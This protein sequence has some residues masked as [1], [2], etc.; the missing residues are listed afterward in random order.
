MFLYV[1]QNCYYQKLED[2]NY[3]HKAPM[4][5]V[6]NP[7]LRFLQFYSDKPYVIATMTEFKHGKPGFV[8]YKIKRVG[9]NKIPKPNVCLYMWSLTFCCVFM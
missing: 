7:C 6:L 3:I 9:M 8:E 1:D 5:V 4:K 2:G